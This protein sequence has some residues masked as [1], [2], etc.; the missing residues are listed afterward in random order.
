MQV[1]PN[2]KHLQWPE[3]A[4]LHPHCVSS[5]HDL[6]TA[7]RSVQCGSQVLSFWC[8]LVYAKTRKR[9]LIDLLHQYGLCI[10]YD[11]VIEITKDLGTAV[12][13]RAEEEG[14]VCPTLLRKGLFTTCAV[15]NLDHNPSSTTAKSSFHG[16]GVSFF[17]APRC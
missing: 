7:G 6:A 15:D 11:R 2:L 10:S 16:T 13:S 14:V 17:S 3:H 1:S 4:F 9:H 12:V 8:H 5:W